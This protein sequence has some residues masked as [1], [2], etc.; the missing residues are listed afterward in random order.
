MAKHL[1]IIY[2]ESSKISQNEYAVLLL[3]CTKNWN[4]KLL[5]LEMIGTYKNWNSHRLKLGKIETLQWSKLKQE[6]RF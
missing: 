6:A 5:E 4:L 1:L 2:S 3:K